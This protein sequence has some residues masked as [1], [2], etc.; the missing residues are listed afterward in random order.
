MIEFNSVV[1]A[2]LVREW[3][4][5]PIIFP[6]VG[7]HPERLKEA[8][9]EALTENHMVAI[10]AGSS[11]GE[12]DFTAQIVE[13]AGELLVH[14]IDIMPGKPAVLGSAQGKP[15]L[16]IPG[17]P[18]SAIVVAREIMQPALVKFLGA[19]LTDQLKIRAV[20]PKKLPSPLGLEEFVRVNLGR[21]Q[22]TLL[23]VPLRRGAGD[24]IERRVNGNRLVVE[25][26]GVNLRQKEFPGLVKRSFL[27]IPFS[28][29]CVR[30]P[31]SVGLPPLRPLRS[32]PG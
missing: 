27:E 26:G 23:A 10:I 3:G 9:S 15:V 16:G 4:G 17:Y 19:R 18:V 20:V 31:K 29:H 2:A 24:P 21:V 28:C 1:L 5:E 11:A 25:G 8:L 32:P 6:S 22:E 7:D 14:G 30:V 13:E 12:H